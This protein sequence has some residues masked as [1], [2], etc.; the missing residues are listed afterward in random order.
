M[1]R[2]TYLGGVLGTSMFFALILLGFLP[3]PL[4]E[5]AKKEP[6]DALKT[7]EQHLVDTYGK[8]PLSFEANVG[9][10]SCA[11]AYPKAIC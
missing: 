10:W 5:A 4:A 7:T 1:N 2:K 3:K 9:R 8:L 11:R 6:A